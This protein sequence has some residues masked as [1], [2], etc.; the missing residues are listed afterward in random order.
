MLFCNNE[1]KWRWFLEKFASLM[2]FLS[3]MEEI[4]RGLKVFNIHHCELFPVAVWL[5]FQFY[6]AV[7]LV[8]SWTFASCW[9]CFVCKL[10]NQHVF[11]FISWRPYNFEFCANLK[12]K[13]VCRSSDNMMKQCH[14]ED[15]STVHLFPFRISW[16]KI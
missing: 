5:K 11:G 7:V 15:C 4:R 9:C 2:F 12:S 6:D 3:E 13:L 1:F 16:S 14:N 8:F 10:E